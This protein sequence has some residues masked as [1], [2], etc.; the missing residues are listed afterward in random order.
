MNALP[1]KSGYLHARRVEETL[2][3][4]LS[5]A[6]REV[7]IEH[8]PLYKEPT[9]DISSS[10]DSGIFGKH[11]KDKTFLNSKEYKEVGDRKSVV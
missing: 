9:I 2:N 1:P 7:M 10:E 3:N 4:F 5:S 11:G 6:D 8:V